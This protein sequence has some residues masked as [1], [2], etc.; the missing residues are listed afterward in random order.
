[1]AK[2][3]ANG[4]R[5]AIRGFGSFSLHDRASRTGRNP[6]TGEAVA[7]AHKYGPHFK[8][9]KELKE[10]VNNLFQNKNVFLYFLPC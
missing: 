7:I 4:K 9:G 10:R 1:M 8:P 6:K 2:T 5:I 3:F